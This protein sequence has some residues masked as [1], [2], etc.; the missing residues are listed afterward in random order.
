MI[1]WRRR[2][3]HRCSTGTPD[4]R[5]QDGLL[6][7]ATDCLQPP[8]AEPA[9]PA[10]RRGRLT[11]PG[12]AGRG[13][14]GVQEGKITLFGQTGK[15]FLVKDSGD[16]PGISLFRAAIRTSACAR[17]GPSDNHWSWE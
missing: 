11:A 4:P 8:N 2:S 10:A 1:L 12:A 7:H 5:R 16:S 9:S 13:R 15:H 6:R 3:E 14:A 17:P